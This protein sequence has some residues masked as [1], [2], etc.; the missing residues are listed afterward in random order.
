VKSCNNLLENQLDN[1]EQ[2]YIPVI[3]KLP[4]DP[5]WCPDSISFRWEG[6]PKQMGV[7][8]GMENM[9]K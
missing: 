8:P 7:N 9:D 3:P 1:G 4:T 5:F 6:L 2:K